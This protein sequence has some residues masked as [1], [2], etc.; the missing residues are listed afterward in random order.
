MFNGVIWIPTFDQKKGMA[1]MSPESNGATVAGVIIGALSF[2]AGAFS[3]IF[4]SGRKIENFKHSLLRSHQRHDEHDKKFSELLAMFKR[5]DNG[6]PRFVTSILCE[7]ERG[8]CHTLS[9]ERFKK[10]EEDV[11][12]VKTAQSDNFKEIIREIRA[13][14]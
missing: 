5:E 12:E 11:R 3:A 4:G 14:K 2:L 7:G 1:R 8:N 13:I 10:L 6:E 9:A